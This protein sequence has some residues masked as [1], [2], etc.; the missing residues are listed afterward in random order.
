MNL[1]ASKFLVDAKALML[2]NAKFKEKLELN[3]AKQI[4]HVATFENQ[5]KN[6]AI[7]TAYPKPA[8]FIDID[9][10]RVNDTEPASFENVYKIV[11]HVEDKIIDETGLIKHY[12][13]TEII[14]NAFK[15]VFPELMGGT[16]VFDKKGKNAPVNTIT[17]EI[18]ITQRTKCI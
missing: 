12:A 7:E 10:I 14:K 16:I 13:L 9:L 18:T 15:S 4:A 3:G 5:P 1:F 2:E 11:L 6:E 17:F 8:C